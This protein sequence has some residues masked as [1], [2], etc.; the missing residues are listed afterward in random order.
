VGPYAPDAEPSPPGLGLT[1]LLRSPGG[2]WSARA[3]LDVSHYRASLGDVTYTTFFGGQHATFSQS[4]SDATDLVWAL[5]GVQREARSS[6]VAPHV[7]LMAGVA[8][9]RTRVGEPSVVV[10]DI[11]TGLREDRT[12]FAAAA[13]GGIRWPIDRNQ[14]F[15]LT[16]DAD[17]RWTGPINYVTTPASDAAGNQLES[18]RSSI[19]VVTAQVGLA[20]RWG[21]Y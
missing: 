6:F 14:H 8:S 1:A 21:G 5:A 13:G 10:F 17:Y 4:L 9:M 15:A 3:S 11:D 12:I 19:E 16:M 2:A 20:A 7:H 18:K